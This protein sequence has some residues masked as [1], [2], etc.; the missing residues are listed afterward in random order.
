[1]TTLFYVDH[2]A[3][4]GH[5]DTVMLTCSY[6]HAANPSGHNFC[7]SCGRPLKASG[8]AELT[9]SLS[10]F[11]IATQATSDPLKLTYWLYSI[12][13]LWIGLDAIPEWR[14]SLLNADNLGLDN[15]QSVRIRRF[16][17]P[18]YPP[19]AFAELK[20]FLR[21][22]LPQAFF[23]S[24]QT[25]PSHTIKLVTILSQADSLEQL[26][27]DL[28]ELGEAILNEPSTSATPPL[29]DSLS[30]A[31]P[32]MVD[33]TNS[34]NSF[35][36]APSEKIKNM[37]QGPQ[38]EES[39]GGED[40]EEIEL[41]GD[42]AD[43]GESTMV[44]P[45]SLVDIEEAGRSDVGKQRDH[46]E[47]CFFIRSSTQKHADNNGQT[48]QAHSLYVLCDGMGGH[49]GGEVASRLAAE[50]LF[51]YFTQH[52]PHPIPG[53]PTRPLP[54][55]D[56]IVEAVRLAN[57]AIFEV[58]EKEQRAGHER[59]GTTLVMVLLQGTE[60][61]V[62]H[63]GDSRLYQ[64]ARRSGLR[65]VTTD[66]EVGQREMQRGIPQEIAYA[67][68]DAYQLTQALG[69]RGGQELA[70]S[71]AYLRFSED[72]LLLL[73]SD[74]LSD[75]NLVEDYK[76]SHLDPILRGKK[77]ISVGVDDL[78]TLAN[79]V[80]GHDN[81]S[82]IAIRTKVRPDLSAVQNTPKQVRGLTRLSN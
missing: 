57:Q 37:S 55:E 70:P 76:E 4:S 80:N 25:R 72:T 9:E 24:G 43:S 18:S 1:M 26:R 36:I 40:V 75:N 53:Q 54:T 50:T 21:S 45:M 11:A 46:N 74:G 27:R 77:D 73:C 30:S 6:C 28:S 81:I 66:H 38:V 19:A 16:D 82:A 63:V 3:P 44:L 34:P 60:A 5:V 10:S 48:A 23:E 62:A 35:N 64:Y 58:N 56:I 79:E 12:T 67:R 15:E 65:Q 51:S 47:D 7:Q 69:P 31:A 41:I 13:E 20:A 39:S 32:I 68:P 78:M 52:W 14:A 22:L 33:S 17:A 71:V 59:M 49:A 42:P 29:S 61:A 2:V 8:S